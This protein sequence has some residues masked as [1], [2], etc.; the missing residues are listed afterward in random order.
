M[1]NV[2]VVVASSI[3]DVMTNLR[4]DESENLGRYNARA[5]DAVTGDCCHSTE[6]VKLTIVGEAEVE[7][8]GV[9]NYLPKMVAGRVDWRL[10]GNAL[11]QRREV[12]KY[13]SAIYLSSRLRNQSSELRTI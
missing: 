9:P 13:T 1:R 11:F 10:Q 12:S 6:L 8:A 3:K 5:S 7:I 4:L 2:L